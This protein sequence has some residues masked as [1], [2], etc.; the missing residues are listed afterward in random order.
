M[1]RV[2]TAWTRLLPL[3]LGYDD[4]K[5]AASNR[6]GIFVIESRTD[7]VCLRER[8]IRCLAEGETKL[9]LCSVIDSFKRWNLRVTCT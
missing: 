2:A 1:K 4:S 5:Q 9:N 8:V 3:R 7:D 6:H